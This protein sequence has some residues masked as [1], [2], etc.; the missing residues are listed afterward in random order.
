MRAN[1]KNDHVKL[2]LLG[3]QLSNQPSDKDQNF[4][5]GGIQGAVNICLPHYSPM[6]VLCKMMF[7]ENRI[8]E[9]LETHSNNCGACQEMSAFTCSAT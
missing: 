5:I 9:R 4:Y 1:G 2:L 8:M 7:C 6:K 3:W